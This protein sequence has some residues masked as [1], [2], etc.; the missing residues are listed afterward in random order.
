M[1]TRRDGWHVLLTWRLVLL[2]LDLCRL[3][4]GEVLW[5]ITLPHVQRQRQHADKY[6]ALRTSWLILTQGTVMT[7]MVINTWWLIS[8]LDLYN[9]YQYY[10]IVYYQMVRGLD[11]GQC[12]PF[13]SFARV[14]R[15][16]RRIISSRKKL[17]LSWSISRTIA[18]NPPSHMFICSAIEE[19]KYHSFPSFPRSSGYNAGLQLV[20]QKLSMMECLQLKWKMSTIRPTFLK[21]RSFRT[22]LARLQ[23]L[24]KKMWSGI[25]PLIRKVRLMNSWMGMDSD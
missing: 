19:L 9:L 20:W 17:Y 3:V 6:V 13:A 15:F 12:S 25:C 7:R 10:Y 1:N 11:I 4:F 5:W 23:L 2:L 24:S 8:W 18:W 21:S 14:I 22:C 16:R